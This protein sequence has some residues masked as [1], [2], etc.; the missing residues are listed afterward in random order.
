MSRGLGPGRKV[1]RAPRRRRAADAGPAFPTM[2][3]RGAAAR[4]GRAGA[5]ATL[6][7][8]LRFEPADVSIMKRIAAASAVFLS[9]LGAAGSSVAQELVIT[10]ARILDG[11]GRVIES[12]SVVVS[13]RAH[14]ARD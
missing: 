3:V 6:R 14:R 4:R 10:N 2:P 1:E 8:T 5:S 9:F 12:G 11:T 7:H 13:R